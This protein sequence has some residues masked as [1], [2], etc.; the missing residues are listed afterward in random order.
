VRKPEHE[1]RWFTQ[2]DIA[3]DPG[4]SEDSRIL[5]SELLALAAP[6]P[7]PPFRW[8]PG[9][10]RATPTGHQGD[11]AASR[12]SSRAGHD[13]VH[14]RRLIV[15]RGNSASGKSE[16]A[17]TI[18]EKYGRGL[19]IV[20]QDNLRRIVLREHDK[21]GGANIGLIDLTTRFALSRGYHTVVE[22]IFNASHYGPMLT[23]LISDH[24]GRAFAYFLDVPFPESLR[25]HATK[26]GTLKYGEAEMR[27]WY[28]GLD[29]L[30][31]G[32]EHVI[33]AESSL[34]EP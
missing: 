6:Q 8:L 3:S 1:V 24:P 4:I 15:I 19:A 32:I 28:R 33:P 29:L 27:Q 13:P 17:A 2:A 21:P 34:E 5:A 9:Q 23:A 18:R 16:A 31:G 25:R 10:G 12:G 22:G 30:P 11:A 20:G 14:E 7:A 26:T